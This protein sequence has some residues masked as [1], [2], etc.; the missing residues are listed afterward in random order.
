[1]SQPTQAEYLE[2]VTLTGHSVTL[3]P[4][5]LSHAEDL[6]EALSQDSSLWAYLPRPQP[7]SL[8]EMVGWIQWSLA[9]RDE[10]QRVPFTV[11]DNATGKAIGS[12]CYLD[13]SAADRHLEIGWTWY[14]P[15]HQR[16]AVNTECKYLLMTRAFEALGCQRVQLRTD[17][18]NNRSQ[19][20]I[21]RLGCTREGVLRDV[22]LMHDGHR[23]S[24]VFYSLLDHEWPA[25]RAWFEERLA[26]PA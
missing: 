18:R 10:G 11:V 17:L 21:E 14:A 22:S 1:M 8:D 6:S 9:S 19:R 26:V 25:R 3:R 2:R 13:I 23:R 20:A 4:L 7:E 24:V 12:T 15:S 5:E 16:T